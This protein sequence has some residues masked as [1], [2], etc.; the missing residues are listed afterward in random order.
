MSGHAATGFITSFVLKEG[1]ET[2]SEGETGTFNS[3]TMTSQWATGGTD[4]CYL[5]MDQRQRFCFVSNYTSGS[6]SVFP[7]RPDR[8]LGAPCCFR[9]HKPYPA[10]VL[11][12]PVEDRQEG[13]HAHQARLMEKRPSANTGSSDKGADDKVSLPWLYVPDLGLD[14]VV[15]YSVDMSNGMLTEVAAHD[16]PAGG[17]PR[18]MD[19][20]PQDRSKVAYVGMEMGNA[21]SVCGIDPW[22]GALTVVQTLS[23]LPEDSGMVYPENSVAQVLVHPSGKF[24]YASNRGHD[25]I[26]CFAVEARTGRLTPAGHFSTE[27]ECPRNFQFPA[28]GRLCVA[29]NQNSHSCVTYRV[30]AATGALT[31]TGHSLSV[32]SPVCCGF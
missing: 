10:Q 23:T 16:M 15:Q 2:N 19:W 3:M 20:L 27:G 25:S 13:P 11:P 31:L 8:S 14:K 29:A 12:G 26:A 5:E 7:V 4:S 9:Q 17:G 32:P 22:T 28:E 6:V 30:D 1:G 21:V 18:H 24:V